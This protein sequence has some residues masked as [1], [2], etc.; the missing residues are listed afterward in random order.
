MRHWNSLKAWKWPLGWKVLLNNDLPEYSRLNEEHQRTPYAYCWG[1]RDTSW[2]AELLYNNRI[3]K[4]LIIGKI[5]KRTDEKLERTIKRIVG[6][7]NSSVVIHFACLFEWVKDYSWR[8]KT[9]KYIN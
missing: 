4:T 2:S 3:H 7:G 9:W 1:V 6:L 8:F 5:F